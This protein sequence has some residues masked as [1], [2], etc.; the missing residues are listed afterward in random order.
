M[1]K[2]EVTVKL[3]LPERGGIVTGGNVDEAT[4]CAFSEVT[5][6]PL[7]EGDILEDG[8]SSIPD[9]LEH[10]ATKHC[11]SSLLC[12]NHA[13]VQKDGKHSVGSGDGNQV[14]SLFWRWILFRDLLEMWW[15]L[16]W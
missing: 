7:P 5:T 4:R 12:V 6:Q 14:E 8:S 3:D 2:V 15:L 9:G 13:L 10:R 11:V 16:L 1:L